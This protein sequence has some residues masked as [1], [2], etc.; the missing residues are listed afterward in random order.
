MKNEYYSLYIAGEATQSAVSQEVPNNDGN[1]IAASGRAAGR[2][3]QGTALGGIFHPDMY[4]LTRSILLAV[5]LPGDLIEHPEAVEFK[6]R[7]LGHEATIK[8]VFDAFG[9]ILVMRAKF[10]DE[11][12]KLRRIRRTLAR[13]MNEELERHGDWIWGGQGVSG[14]LVG[15]VEP[16]DPLLLSVSYWE[17]DEPVGL[18]VPQP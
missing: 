2:P 13:A 14:S 8:Y 15:G 1:H 10:M 6:T 9:Q 12:G 4:K 3:P 5:P 16:N 18:R 7:W 11:P 17:P